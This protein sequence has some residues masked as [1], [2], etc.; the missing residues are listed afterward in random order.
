MDDEAAGPDRGPRVGSRVVVRHRLERPDLLTGATLTDVVGELVASDAEALLVRT[1]RGEVRVPRPL[2]TVVKEVPPAPSRRGAPHRALSVEGLQRVMV[3]AWPAVETARLGDWLLRASGGFTHRANSVVTVG[4]PGMPVPDALDA[5]E[6][7]YAA[8]GLPPD[9]TVAVPLEADVHD[10]PV[11]VEALARGWAPRVPTLTLT[12]PTRLLAHHPRPDRPGG[13]HRVGDVQGV[14][15]GGELTPQ[16][17][18]AF[19]SYR[20]VD[21]EA[22]ARAVL[23]GSPAQVFATARDEGGRVVGI[24]R[25]AVAA[26]WGGVAAMWVAP[27]A[28]RRGVASAVLAALAGAAGRAGAAS[29]HLQTDSDNTAALRLFEGHGFE[30]HHAYVNLRRLAG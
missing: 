25:L 7:W 4:S 24:G 19:R 17:F 10:D 11:A 20:T 27:D 8:R 29:V 21:D 28:R 23:T 15:V 30:R 22:V 6:R 18:E 14:E 16:W 2:V 13:P 1:R 26:A 5:V 3:E 12:A 9:V